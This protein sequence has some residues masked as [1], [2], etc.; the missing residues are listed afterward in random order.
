MPSLDVA[1]IRLRSYTCCCRIDS[2]H[3][4]DYIFTVRG[5]VMEK[6]GSRTTRI[7]SSDAST[8]TIV[9]A[10]SIVEVDEPHCTPTQRI[11]CTSRQATPSPAAL[12]YVIEEYVPGQVLG[13]PQQ[14][15]TET[16]G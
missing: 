16:S 4:G 9:A 11:K 5:R 3:V 1:V 7:G 13:E 2:I 14:I 8:Q 6:A 15:L 10:I 12:D